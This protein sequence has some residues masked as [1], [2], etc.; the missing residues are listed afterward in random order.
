MKALKFGLAAAL[1]C[2]GS[3]ALA[4]A[5]IIDVTGPVS[6]S[7]PA[8]D[9]A[10]GAMVQFTVSSDL[11]NATIN[12]DTACI[13]CDGVAFLLTDFGPSADLSNVFASG[14]FDG[15]TDPLL[16][17]SSLSAGTY[18][19]FLATLNGG[20]VW[21]STAS[22]TFNLAPGASVGS[23]FITAGF[24]SNVP[25]NS[26][27]DFLAGQDLLFTVTAD[28]GDVTPSVPEPRTWLMF[29]LGFGAIGRA[30]RRRRPQVSQSPVLMAG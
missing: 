11:T 7:S 27:F 25:F 8:F 17:I 12:A 13:S 22:A 2:V 1:L 21:N 29:I 9:A 16:S 14:S 19:L 3:P 20:F 6:G 15:T 23:S 30:L 5:T 28:A 18:Y 26:N 4:A 24:D 10:G